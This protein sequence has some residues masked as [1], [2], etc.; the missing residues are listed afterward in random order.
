MSGG[1]WIDPGSIRFFRDPEGRLSASRGAR[2]GA[3]TARRLFPAADPL[4]MIRIAG[5]EEEEWGVLRAVEDLDPDSRRVME[6][7][8]RRHPVLPRIEA[9]LAIRR[10]IGIF[11][12]TA[13][14][15]GGTLRFETG[16]LYEAVAAMP[17]GARLVTD[18]DGRC[19]LLPADGEWDA[20]SRKR[21]AR[22]L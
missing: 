16:P 13:A 9:I 1:V 6:D 22:W 7:E 19:F 12:W 17:G 5:A 10:R 20:K 3:V 15:E 14:A 21:L 4:R 2:K 18:L 8:L 11:E